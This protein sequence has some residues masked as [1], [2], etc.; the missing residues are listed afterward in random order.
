MT[1]LAFLRFLDGAEAS[2][3]SCAADSGDERPRATAR[4]RVAD[5]RVHLN[6]LQVR[7]SEQFR[8][9]LDWGLLIQRMLGER[10]PKL[11][12]PSE[13]TAS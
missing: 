7:M 11:I 8:H 2:L 10:M 3:P 4:A 9:I 1:F 5:L 6:L 12:R 13:S